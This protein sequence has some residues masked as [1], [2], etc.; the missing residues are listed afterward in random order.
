VEN[1]SLLIRVK[2]RLDDL[3]TINK[4]VDAMPNTLCCSKKKRCEIQLVLEELFTNIVNH[5]FNDREEHEI[6]IEVKCDKGALVIRMED[7]GAPFN[8]TNCSSPD[9]RCAIE[10]R[11][12]GGLGIHFVKHF[13]DSCSYERKN[14]KNIMILKK[15]H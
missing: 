10:E 5:G 11:L 14:N 13:I 2:N 3:E 12:V 4:A 8:P 1:F 6:E 9:T 15:S 7:D